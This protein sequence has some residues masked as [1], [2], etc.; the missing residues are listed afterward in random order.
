MDKKEVKRWTASRKSELIIQSF[1]SKKS[2]AELCRQEGIAQST[3]F[4]WKKDF[5]SGG[6]SSLKN[7][8]GTM[9]NDPSQKLAETEHKLGETAVEK[10]ILQEAVQRQFSKKKTQLK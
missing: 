9:K 10:E 6:T 2:T 1:S 5:I 3:F 8:N 4:Q 7:G